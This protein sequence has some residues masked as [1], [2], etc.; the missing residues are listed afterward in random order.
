[1]DGSVAKDAKTIITKVLQVRRRW[2]DDRT[3]V[4]DALIVM[5]SSGS[6]CLY[7]LPRLRGRRALYDKLIEKLKNGRDMVIETPQTCS[8]RNRS[9]LDGADELNP[10]LRSTRWI[11]LWSCPTWT[12]FTPAD[13]AP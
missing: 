5:S 6:P 11:Q 4:R 10:S 12:R 13:I 7:P 9:D 1:M 2:R 8:R 3:E